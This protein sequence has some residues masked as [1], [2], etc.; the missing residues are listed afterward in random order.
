MSLEPFSVLYS[1]KSKLPT[2]DEFSEIIFNEFQSFDILL[3][4][5]KKDFIDSKIYLADFDFNAD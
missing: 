4:L 2:V 3:F 1:P 5:I